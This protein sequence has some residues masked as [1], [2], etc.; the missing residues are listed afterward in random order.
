VSFLTGTN[1]ELLYANTAAGTAKNTFTSEVQINDTAGMGAQASLPAFFFPSS[2]TTAGKSLRIVARGIFSTTGT[3]TFTFTCRLGAAGSTSAA[4]VLGSAALTTGSGVANQLF[5]FEGDVTLSA[6]SGAAGANT[7]ARGTGLIQSP[8]L[9]S[10]F[11]G[12]LFGGA[13]SPGTVATV[14]TSITN[15]VNFNV[16]CSVSSASNTITLLHLMVF[17]LN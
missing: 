11:S 9:A 14:D 13:A 12:A 8:G 17:G 15:Y 3:P 7:T 10:P 1:V 5:E 2:P 6:P 4:I 16:A